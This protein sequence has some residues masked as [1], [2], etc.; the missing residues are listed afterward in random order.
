MRSARSKTVTSCPALLSCAAADSPAGSAAD[1]RDLLASPAVGRVRDDPTLL[2]TTI[3]DVAFNRF[4]GDRRL[5]NPQ[6]T[7]PLTRSRTDTTGELREV[8]CLVQSI[9]G[10]LPIVMIDEVVP[11]GDE[12]MHRT[13]RRRPADDLAGVTERNPTVH[14]PRPLMLE[15]LQLERLIKLIPV[16][17]ALERVTLSRRLTRE[18][19]ESGRF[20]HLS[21]V[22]RDCENHGIHGRYGKVQRR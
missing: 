6:R 10:L 1:D 9:E 22:D 18:L 11:F 17:D 5:V 15:N 3:D 4:D 19:F 12:V 8:V 16:L 13:P 2:E 20:T 21:L 14:A 7:R